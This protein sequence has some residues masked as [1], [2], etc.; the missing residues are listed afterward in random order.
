M[1]AIHIFVL[2]SVGGIGK[3]GPVRSGKPFSKT[4]SNTCKNSVLRGW[5]QLDW[6]E[7]QNTQ[8]EIVACVPSRRENKGKSSCKTGN[9]NE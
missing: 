2:F 1:P 6:W 3:D 9:N 8:S 7:G 4:S 5:S